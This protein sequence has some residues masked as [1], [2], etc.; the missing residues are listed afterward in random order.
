MYSYGERR[1]SYT[2][3]RETPRIH[4]GEVAVR[5][6]TILAVR[7]MR[8]LVDIAPIFA[9]GFFVAFGLLALGNQFL[10]WPA[11]F[12]VAAILAL[13]GGALAVSVAL[14]RRVEDGG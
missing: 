7:G 10:R 14:R 8:R 3:L 12:E 5:G 11:T 1:G 9:F 13:G 6:R 4:R 2:N